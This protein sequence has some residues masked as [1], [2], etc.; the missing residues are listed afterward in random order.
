MA[1]ILKHLADEY[2]LQIF[3]DRKKANGIEVL[4]TSLVGE[5]MVL[6]V[7]LVPTIYVSVRTYLASSFA[8]IDVDQFAKVESAKVSFSIKRGNTLKLYDDP[9][10]SPLQSIR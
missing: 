5:I 8:K 4:T 3:S 2:K 1:I 6:D 10:V 7:R 9:A